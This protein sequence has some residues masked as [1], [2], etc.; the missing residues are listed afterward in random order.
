MSSFSET[1]PSDTSA[2]KHELEFVRKWSR[3]PGH[4]SRAT[5]LL[6]NARPQDVRVANESFGG[7]GL[8]LKGDAIVN[9]GDTVQVVCDG[10]GQC[11][12][13]RRIEPHENGECLLG[14]EWQDRLEPEPDAESP[15]K[16]RFI[17]RYVDYQGLR[18]VCNLP[19]RPRGGEATVVLPGGGTWTVA[20]GLVLARTPGERRAELAQSPAQLVSLA[21]HYGLEVADSSSTES[22]V[23]A[24]LSYEFETF[25]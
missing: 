18:V 25:C 4:V 9:V 19:H 7:I 11:G 17:A 24:L 21:R 8:I 2:T 15:A 20:S 1:M 23:G 12:L 16:R 6:P 3:Y 14:I 13:V 5:L 22:L 10:I